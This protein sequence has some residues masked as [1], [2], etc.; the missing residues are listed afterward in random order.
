MCFRPFEIVTGG[1]K[2]TGVEYVS[3]FLIRARKLVGR[4]CIAFT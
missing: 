4:S 1:G 2:V 3:D